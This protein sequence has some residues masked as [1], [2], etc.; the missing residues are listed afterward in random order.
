LHTSELL[1]A[2]R[3]ALQIGGDV[4][5]RGRVVLPT[6]ELALDEVSAVWC[7]SPWFAPVL[8]EGP[9]GEGT[10]FARREVEGA[11]HGLFGLLRGAF[12][13]NH[14]NAVYAAEDKLGQ[15][16]WA[17]GLGMRIPRTLVTNDAAEAR[18]FFETCEGEM[19]VKSFRRH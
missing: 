2:C 12:W 19:I 10:D 14:P 4:L 5:S 13:M 8:T 11:L 6:G 1:N 17:R 3:L 18:E 9:E 15:L 16:E 7:A